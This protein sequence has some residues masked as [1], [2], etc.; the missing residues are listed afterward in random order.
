M[1]RPRGKAVWRLA[2]VWLLASACGPGAAT[3]MPEPPTLFD[4][5]QVGQP[6]VE[7]VTHPNDPNV[8]QI[9]GRAGAVPAGATVHITNLD[10]QDP[11]AAVDARADGGFLLPVIVTNG[12]ELRF[13]WL[14]GAR[15]SSAADALFVKTQPAANVFTLEPSPRFDCLKLTPADTLDFDSAAQA[16][17]TL[18]NNC[19]EPL[20]LSNAR[21][22]LGLTDFALQTQPATALEPGTKSELVVDFTRSQAGLREDVLLLDVTR[23]ATTIRYPITLRAN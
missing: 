4:L 14:L 12:E 2:G 5:N 3:P 15:R 6:Q 20:A 21:A 7:V 10:R 8:E 18:E 19:P 11:P 9:E 22:R 23:A 13:E 1:S 17:L 16:S